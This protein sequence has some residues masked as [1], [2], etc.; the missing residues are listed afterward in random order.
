MHNLPPSGSWSG[1]YVY[2]DAAEKHRMRLRLSFSPN[3]TISGV[4]D[5]DVAPFTIR[6]IFDRSANCANW[7]KAYIGMHTIDYRGW[8]DGRSI[9]GNWVLVP[10]SGGFWIW[11]DTL[12]SE[13]QVHVEIEQPAET[14]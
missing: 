12:G 13:E 1:Y 11:P 2:G 10:V 3:G 8:Y 5:D 6:G 9:C 7:T 4:G 14:A